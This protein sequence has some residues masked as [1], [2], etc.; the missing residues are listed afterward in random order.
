M[1][2]HVKIFLDYYDL[3]GE[4][5]MCQCCNMAEA[6]DIHH[7]EPKGMGGSEEKDFIENLIALCRECHQAVHA[8]K[9]SKEFLKNIISHIKIYKGIWRKW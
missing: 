1:K 4:R 3:H 7:I 9:I 6:V 5:I 8:E 2:K